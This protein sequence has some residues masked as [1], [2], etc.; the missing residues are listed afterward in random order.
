MSYD[1]AQIILLKYSD[2]CQYIF[3]PNK[4]WSHI[5]SKQERELHSQVLQ[6][7]LGFQAMSKLKMKVKLGG[8]GCV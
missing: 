3:L 7:I 4:I 2:H 8:G 5:H 1:S 6:A